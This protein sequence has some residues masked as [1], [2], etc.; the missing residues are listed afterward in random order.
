VVPR[1]AGVEGFAACAESGAM[2]AVVVALFTGSGAAADVAGVADGTALVATGG[3]C[4]LVICVLW[5]G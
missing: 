1:E 3:A 5:V 4:A 2:A